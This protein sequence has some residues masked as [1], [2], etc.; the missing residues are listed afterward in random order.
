MKPVPARRYSVEA[1]DRAVSILNTFSDGR[2]TRSLADVARAAGL[3]QPTTLR[4]LS[5]LGQH[6][7]VERNELGGYRLGIGLFRLGQRALDGRDPR[8]IAVPFME[9]LL[10]QFQE[11]VTLDMRVGD[12]LITVEVLQGTRSIRRGAAVG[13]QDCWHTTSLGKALLASLP[14]PEAKGILDRCG[15]EALTDKTLTTFTAMQKEFARIRELGYAVDDEESEEGTRCV[16]AAIFDHQARPLFALS[17]SGPATRVTHKL[18]PQ[19]GK[20][21]SEAAALTSAEFGYE[22][23]PEVQRGYSV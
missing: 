7:F 13:V 1:V 20:E 19:I 15:Y 4:Y 8:K 5:S 17:V 3:S 22:V 6:G 12:S 18:V 16:G 10:R 14:E 9:H 23:S 21:V 2:S 11:T